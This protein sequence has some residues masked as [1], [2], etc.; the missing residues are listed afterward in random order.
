VGSEGRGELS[1]SREEV[2][3]IAELA[4][5]RPD[6]EA[7]GRLTVELNGILEQIRLLEEVEWPEGEDERE[8]FVPE[9]PFREPELPPDPLASGA[10]GDRA[11]GWTDGFFAVPR[12]AAL[13]AGDP[14]E[15][16]R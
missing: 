12:L 15:E 8:P 2:A 1:V 13:D 16:E 3:R 7:I 6:E 5:L 10:P 4:K 11:P 14:A 9:T